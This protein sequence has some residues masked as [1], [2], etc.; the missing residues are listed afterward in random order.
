MIR[1]LAASAATGTVLA[2][3]VFLHATAVPA[4]NS[5]S[6][7][8][9]AHGATFDQQGVWG[10]WKIIY[11]DSCHVGPKARKVNLE[12]LDLSNL[13]Q[14]GA[15]WETL[16]RVL[17]AGRTMPPAG[18][19]RP[20][21]A[22][23]DVLVK[24]IEGE[25]DRLVDARP[26]P[27]RPTLHRLNREEYANAV[28]DLLAFDIDVSELLPADDS[29]YGFDN[30]GDV[31]T[32][33]PTLMERYLL[34]AS[35]ISRQAVGDTTMPPTYVTYSLP[36]GLKQDDRMSDDLPVGS[37]G[38]IT[39]KHFFPVDGE[40]EILV[41]LQKGSAQEV[42]GTGRERTLDLRLDDQRVQLFTIPAS[43]ER[44]AAADVTGVRPEA[45]KGYTVR[46]P[47]KAGKHTIAAALLKD[48][49]LQEGIIVKE[50]A[51]VVRAHFEGVGA[52]NIAGPY[53]VQG[54]GTTESPD[55]IFVCHPT[56]N[57]MMCWK[58]PVRPSTRSAARSSD[59]ART[60]SSARPRQKVAKGAR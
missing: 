50:R 41:E 47:M 56:P 2:G 36:H 38:G 39:L 13:S 8:A 17:R 34:A 11:C 6:A 28:R 45:E 18:A 26:V 23:Y 60:Q 49:V 59:P 19:P 37:R 16:L 30:I 27:G 1:T 35:K 55:R 5:D 53:N 15:T 46:V 20:D 7:A 29:G 32:V 54:P 14:S 4:E 44:L 12:G 31:L 10:T 58:P 51:D 48:T 52:I 24:A 22:T 9:A 42:L 25:R 3:A 21:E 40:Y 33:S 43:P 57:G